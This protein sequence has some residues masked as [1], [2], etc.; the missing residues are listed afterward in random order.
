MKGGG[1]GGYQTRG[2]IPLN[3]LTLVQNRNLN[4]QRP[5]SKEG[6]GLTSLKLLLKYSPQSVEYLKC[7]NITL[8][9]LMIN[10][11]VTEQE[12]S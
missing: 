12:P 9:L 10:K 6:V 11:L 8:V 2:L 3:F 5:P 7:S 1:G 4:R